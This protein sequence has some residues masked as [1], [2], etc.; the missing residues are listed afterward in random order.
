MN[1]IEPKLQYR[2]IFI[3]DIHLGTRGSRADLLM[4]FLSRA[5]CETLY[6]VGDIFDGWRLRKSWYWN[7]SFDTVLRHQPAARGGA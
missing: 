4:E 2:S 7:E 3:S 6:L 5:D 1:L